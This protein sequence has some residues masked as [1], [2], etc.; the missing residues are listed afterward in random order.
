MLL[1]TGFAAA[2]SLPSCAERRP[3][4]TKVEHFYLV[5]DDSERLYNFFRDEL[6][7]SVVWPFNSYG[8]FA[9]GGLTLGNVAMEFVTEKGDRTGAAGAEFK[10][11]AF[12]PVGDADAAVAELKRRGLPHGEPDPHKFTWDGQERVGWV[13]IDLTG[14]PPAGAYIFICDYK[15]REEVAGRRSRASGEFAARGGGPLGVTSLKEIVIGV[16]SAEEASRQWGK[17]FNPPGRLA[18][19][20]FAFGP[21]P[22]VRL[23]KAETEGIQSIIVGVQSA[24]RARQ[25]LTEKRMFGGEHEGHMWIAPAAV[26]GLRI[27]LIEG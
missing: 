21:G 19:E 3:L 8:D 25:F 10:G 12:E 5:S 23:V 1:A 18:G 22:K 13:T 20:V 26:G 9:S 24:A 14:F 7:L 17:L 4:L 27:A 2:T 11:I 15:Q 16:K 6:Q